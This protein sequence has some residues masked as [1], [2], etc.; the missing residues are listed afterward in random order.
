MEKEIKIK[1]PDKHIIYGTLNT[2]K[3]NSNIL[4]I[5]VHGLTGHRDEHIFYNGAKFFDKNSIATFRFDLYT[6]NEKGRVLTNSTIS[7]HASDINTVVDYFKKDFKKIF[8]A[9]H[10]LGGASVLKS[11]T[12]K[13]DGII[14]WDSSTK[15]SLKHLKDFIYNKNLNSYTVNW[16]TE[17][18]IGKDM[19]DELKNFSSPKEI[20][21]EIKKPL[22]VIV[23][24]KGSLIKAGREYF[25]YSKNIKEFTVIKGAGHNFNEGNVEQEL[26]KETLSFIKKNK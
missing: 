23:A 7:T 20:I 19:L 6:S 10:S 13:I 1:T 22:K 24:G 26:F 25:K 9:G 21:P 16:G 15:S 18:L 11:N 3:K 14:L 5:F 17:F 12:T 8:I 2:S 4:L